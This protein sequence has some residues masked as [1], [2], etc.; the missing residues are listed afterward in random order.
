MLLANAAFRTSS[1]FYFYLYQSRK[2]LILIA[3]FTILSLQLAERRQLYSAHAKPQNTKA[4]NE[5]NSPPRL[6]DYYRRS[7]CEQLIAARGTRIN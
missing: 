7:N 5:Q 1:I 3:H 2:Q 6:A 4:T